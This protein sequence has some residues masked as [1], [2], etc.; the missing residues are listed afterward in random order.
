M[1]D[2]YAV[3]KMVVETMCDRCSLAVRKDCVAQDWT[4]R[5][6]Q[7]CI[8]IPKIMQPNDQNYPTQLEIFKHRRNP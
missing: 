4:H 8:C 3:W 2:V 1:T 5:Y 7:M 6:K